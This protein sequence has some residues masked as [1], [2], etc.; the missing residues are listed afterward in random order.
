[1]ASMNKTKTDNSFLTSQYR[2][3]RQCFKEARFVAITWFAALFFCCGWIG[4][5][6][7][8]PVSERPNTPQLV[9]GLPAWAVWGLLAPWLILIGVTWFFAAVVLKDDEPLQAMPNQQEDGL[10][11]SAEENNG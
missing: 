3:A 2:H 1:M 9:L 7:Y 6:G 4:Y 8:L 5:F 10:D 11:E